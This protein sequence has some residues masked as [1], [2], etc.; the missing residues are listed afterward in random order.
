MR[1]CSLFVGLAVLLAASEASAAEYLVG[2]PSYPTLASV[3]WSSLGAGDVVTIPYRAMPYRET[4]AITTSGSAAAPIVV[5]GTRGPGGERPVIDGDMAVQGADSH[6]RS[7][8][9]L[10]DG[11]SYVV[12]EGLELVH[13]HVDYAHAGLFPSAN[14]SG[15]Y[16]EDASHAVVRD[17]SVHGN[18]NGIF[19]APGTSDVRIENNLVY[20]NGNSGSTQ[21]HNSYTE[22]DGIVFEGNRYGPLCSGC[23]GNNLKDRSAGTIVRYN[24][25]EGGNRALDLVEAETSDTAFTN[26]VASTPTYVYGN[27]LVKIDDTTQSQVVHFGGDNGDNAI[28]RRTL[29]FYNN[30]IFSTRAV[31]TTFFHFDAETPVADVRNCVYV[32]PSSSQIYLVDSSTDPDTDL[33]LANVF[34]PPSYAVSVDT[35][36]A[37]IVSS[38]GLITGTDAGFVDASGGDFHLTMNSA[39]RNQ[40]T[41]L[42]AGVPALVGE[43]LEP[44]GITARLVDGTLDLGAFERCDGTCAPATLPDGGV[45]GGDG[46]A[47][48]DPA[49]PGRGCGCAAAGATTDPTT[50]FVLFTVVAGMIAF[51]RSRRRAR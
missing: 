2:S 37:T 5:R 17:C 13:A 6:V 45:V 36:L 32:V 3:P 4:F 40:G 21:E 33:H 22:S 18:G 42:V 1:L 28:Y 38:E 30:T 25:L 10:R 49:D 23:L 48:T 46:G 44:A 47:N 43:F 19:S 31:R 9:S 50:T 15:I 51:A 20:G 11:A 14:A 7:L 34:L 26:R 16:I 41:D 27:V 29:R 24:Y 35:S 39:V 12:I 8:I